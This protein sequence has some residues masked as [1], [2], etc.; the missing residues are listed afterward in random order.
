MITDHHHPSTMAQKKV[1]NP[2]DRWP[3]SY[4]TL[5]VVCPRTSGA[6]FEHPNDSTAGSIKR[7]DRDTCCRTFLVVAV[8]ECR[9][10]KRYNI[11]TDARH[12]TIYRKTKIARSSFNRR[13]GNLGNVLH[14][15]QSD[16]GT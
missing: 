6:R 13:N 12:D 11:V 2:T 10:M 15:S 9:K 16:C 5:D 14:A 7:I 1:V 3:P 4:R 8:S